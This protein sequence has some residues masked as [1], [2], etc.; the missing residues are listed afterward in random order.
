MSGVDNEERSENGRPFRGIY[1]SKG[2]VPRQILYNRKKKLLAAHTLTACDNHSVSSTNNVEISAE[3][4]GIQTYEPLDTD[5]GSLPTTE[6]IAPPPAADSVD[7][8]DRV[9]KV[10]LYEGSMLS[11]DTSH[12]LLKSYM[13]RHHL[14]GQ[15][16]EDLLQLLQLH[17]PKENKL[18]SSKYLFQKHNAGE[19]VDLS[20]YHYYC[21][22]CFTTLP[23]SDTAVCPN[24]MCNLEVQPDTSPYFL[25][26][27]VS[28]QLKTL[29]SSKSIK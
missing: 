19:H 14:T 24:T 17:L 2:K 12:L 13:C 7:P 16:Q 26:V 9:P 29:L 1:R 6:I 4:T 27:S 5:Q 23:S 22:E 18:P 15:A 25:T 21:S 11:T 8:A 10:P 3:S 28:D 20:T